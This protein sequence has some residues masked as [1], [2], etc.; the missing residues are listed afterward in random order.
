MFSA[1]IPHSIQCIADQYLHQPCKIQIEPKVTTLTTIK[2]FYTIVS[3]RQKPEILTRF[4]ESEDFNAAIIFMRTKRASF[5]LAKKLKA[6]SY[7][8][9][10]I[11]GDMN[12]ALREK[13]VKQ[14]K[15]GSLDI[16]VATDIAARGLDIVRISHVINYDIPQDAESYVHRIGRTGRAGR[17]GKALL[18][19]TPSERRMLRTIER[20]TRQSI[21]VM[22]PPS[23]VQ[24]SK[25]HPEK[26]SSKVVEIY[27][28]ASSDDGELNA[29][30]ENSLKSKQCDQIILPNAQKRNS[31]DRFRHNSKPKVKRTERPSIMTQCRIEL[32][33]KQ[34]LKPS[35]I[36]KI[37]T[38]K[39]KMISRSIGKIK[40]YKNYTLVDL[41]SN[42]VNKAIK[43]I[44]RQ[45]LGKDLISIR[46]EGKPHP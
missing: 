43:L 20:T 40:I 44:D 27:H 24:I 8:A 19:V 36:V 32:G 21:S 29:Q 41:P 33:L 34:G 14:I 17:E 1:T 45:R 39:A 5:E 12:Q 22:E 2:Q 28:Q 7:A 37:F 23:N 35:D 13:V 4:L 3:Q 25:K 38:T 11:N 46:I 42:S 18:F 16:V 9:A 26:L 10:A 31:K 15:Q 30:K 6:C